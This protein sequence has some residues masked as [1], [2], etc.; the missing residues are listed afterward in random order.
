MPQSCIAGPSMTPCWIAAPLPSS[1]SSI[2]TFCRYLKR[3]V[4][5]RALFFGGEVE[6]S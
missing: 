2:K 5:A 6:A 1:V 3:G 4:C